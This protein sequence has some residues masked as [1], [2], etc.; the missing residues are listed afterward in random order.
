MQA[1]NRVEDRRVGGLEGREGSPVVERAEEVAE[2]RAAGAGARAGRD[3]GR[4]CDSAGV[5]RQ[6]RREDTEGGQ[7]WIVPDGWM[8]EKMTLSNGLLL[9]ER[10]S[11]DEPAGAPEVEA[12]EAAVWSRRRHDGPA[13][14]GV[15]SVCG[16]RAS[17]RERAM[18][19]RRS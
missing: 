19:E 6:E 13:T 17:V 16:I 14:L 11:A 5:G 9:P 15:A 8:P 10:P 4:S 1:N 12:V 18:A 3:G 2:L 7:T